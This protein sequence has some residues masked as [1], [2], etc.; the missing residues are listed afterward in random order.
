LKTLLLYT[1][2]QDYKLN[3]VLEFFCSNFLSCKLE[4]AIDIDSFSHKKNV[5]KMAYSNQAIDG[6]LTVCESD[7]FI[8]FSVEKTPDISEELVV[9]N[10]YCKLDVFASAFFLLARVEEYRDFDKDKHGRFN[11]RQS[12]LSTKGLLEK[13]IVDLW[14]CKL[15]KELE[16]RFDVK[17]EIDSEFEFKSTVDIDHIFAYAEKPI[18]VQVGS[19]SRDLFLLKWHRL[20]DRFLKEDPYDTFDRVIDLHQRNN[21]PLHSFILTSERGRF[22]KSLHPNHSSFIKKILELSRISEIGIHPSYASNSE[23]IHM[24]REKKT[25]E[26]VISKRI[27]SS[28]QHFV[29]LEF[30]KTYRSLLAV[31]INNDF[32]MG[33]PDQSGFRAGTSRSFNWFD[34]IEN[35]VT[36]LII[37]P[38]Q[39]MDVTLK[40]YEKL[41]PH[42]AIAKASKIINN[43]HEVSGTVCLIWHNSSFYNNEGWSGWQDVYEK[44]L[45]LGNQKNSNTLDIK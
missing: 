6:V 9:N 24:E 19:M 17:L 39:L 16:I 30:P 3:Y 36:T 35:K 45:I 1:S 27:V 4:I 25:L 41:D 22:D 37:H 29:K 44:I 11:S 33:Y 42:S 18:S 10:D 13:P 34:L 40:N 20:L 5:L 43:V 21:L 14:F 23:S 26:K 15:K 32:S 2:S 28:R 8:D 38:F 12:I 31:G 7:Y